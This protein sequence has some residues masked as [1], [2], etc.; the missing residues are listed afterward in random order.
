LLAA[1]RHESGTAR[2]TAD[3]LEVA[4]EAAATCAGLVSQRDL[5]LEVAPPARPVRVGVE[6]ELAERILQPILENACRYGTS[7]IRVSIDRDSRAVR[8]AVDDDGPGIAVAERE[9][10]FE[11][12]TRGRLGR[13]NG[14][15]GAGLGLALARRLARGVD[16]DVEAVAGVGAGRFVVTLP[17]G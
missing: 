2:G 5:D 16:G 4:E 12:G 7:S 17:A 15:D 1:A 14:T 3:A 11:P 8:Y 13:E 10:I 6:L 9:E